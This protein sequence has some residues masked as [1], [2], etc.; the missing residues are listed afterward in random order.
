MPRLVF[1]PRYLK[2]Q[3]PSQVKNYVKYV[4]TRPNAEKFEVDQSQ[5]E[6]TEY[7]KKW[8]EK[9]LKAHGELKESCERE[10]ENY[11]QN[12]TKE[13]ATDLI[14]KIA[15]EGLAREDSMENYVGYLA[16]RPR[17]ERGKQG[18][19]L[20]NG[21]DKEID[22]N[23]VAKEVAEHNGNIWTFVLSLKRE[24][25]VRLGYDNAAMWRELVRGKAPEIAKAMGIP[26]EHFVWY[27]AFHNEGHHP[28]IHLM[29]YSKNPKE[30]YLGRQNLMKLR[31]SFANEIFHD[32]LYHIYEQKDEVRDELKKYF[33]RKLK[34]AMA[35][36]DTDHPKAEALL[37]ELSQKLKTTKHKK[38]YGRL[39]KENKILVDEIV[40]EISKDKKISQAYESW[41][42]L[43][44]DILSTYQNQERARRT[45]AD[46]PEFRNIKNMVL[47]SALELSE[48]DE[49]IKKDSEKENHEKVNAK[50]SWEERTKKFHQMQAQKQ[51]LLLMK[52]ISHMIQEDYDRKKQQIHVDKKL[53]R[54][55]M[56]KKEAHG[57]KM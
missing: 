30:G 6:A 13:N 31:S 9:E 54:K 48:I 38:V 17:A 44:D 40:K 46:E 42:G 1:T 27:G 3:K 15:E 7:Q 33:D 45:L 20:W 52:H 19:A 43:K 55:I 51:F 10:Y 21:S 37:W 25:A 56:E 4:A 12:P 28:H 2:M 57:Q 26:V 22:L 11:L 53:M 29:C 34:Q 32:E 47:K 50:E 36:E 23:Q 41:L 5:T 18:H 14:N 16:K 8:I 24:D 35:M 39:E 49:A